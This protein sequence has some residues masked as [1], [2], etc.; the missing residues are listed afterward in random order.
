MPLGAA[1]RKQPVG[2]LAALDHAGMEYEAFERDF[3]EECAALRALSEAEVTAYRAAQRIRV[4]GA[5]AAPRPV[6]SFAQCGFDDELCRALAASRWS[7]PTPIQAQALPAA[8]SGLDLLGVAKTGSGKTGAFLLP[9]LVHIMDQ[10]ELGRGEGPIALIVAPTHELAAQ[11]HAEARRLGRVYDLR[12]CAAFGGLNKHQ[13]FKELKAGAEVRGG[14]EAQGWAPAR[15]GLTA[16]SEHHR[17]AQ[18]CGERRSLLIDARSLAP[19]IPMPADRGV[20]TG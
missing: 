2:S 17:A 15:Q 19:S 11:I 4:S 18:S 10:R 9:A 12:V 20:H 3:Y 13:Q 7:R 14:W 16:I 8:L 5:V 1:G 6:T